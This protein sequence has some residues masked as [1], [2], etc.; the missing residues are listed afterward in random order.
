MAYEEPNAFELLGSSDPHDR[1]FGAFLLGA[2]RFTTRVRDALRK[3]LIDGDSEVVS[4]AA[5]SLALHRDVAS[6][7]T[8]V[9]IVEQQSGQDVTPIAWAA[10]TLAMGGSKA[11]RDRVRDVL[12]R[13]EQRGS[14]DV[15]KQVK[16]LM[17]D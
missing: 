8:I 12:T 4:Y 7:D 17:R 5:Q 11:D 16:I 13:L 1:A 14:P 3:S 6:L 10:A 15:V 9:S 2:A